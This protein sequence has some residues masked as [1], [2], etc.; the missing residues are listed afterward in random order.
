M[1]K[2]LMSTLVIACIVSAI[3][4][5]VVFL[6]QF[7]RNSESPAYQT[8]N[9]KSE[10][11]EAREGETR[12]DEAQEMQKSKGDIVY[13]TATSEKVCYAI[14]CDTGIVAAIDI[15]APGSVPYKCSDDSKLRMTEI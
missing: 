14:T 15:P 9:I 12:K 8:E 11:T 6:N 13:C 3:L 10:K 1:K 4:L 7:F 5:G 2:N